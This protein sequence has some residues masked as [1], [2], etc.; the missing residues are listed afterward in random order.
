MKEYNRDLCVVV[1]W[2]LP[3]GHLMVLS[4]IDIGECAGQLL[5]LSLFSSKQKSNSDLA[6]FIVYC[7]SIPPCDRKLLLF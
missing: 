1:C 4:T 7:H 2:D 3:N 5:L 6:N